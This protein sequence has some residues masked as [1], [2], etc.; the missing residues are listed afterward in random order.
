MSDQRE[1]LLERV[2]RTISTMQAI[3]ADSR[4]PLQSALDIVEPLRQL[5]DYRRALRAK[6]F[7][8]AAN[9]PGYAQAIARLKQVADTLATDLVTFQR[10]A[11]FVAQAAQAADAVLKVAIAVGA[12]AG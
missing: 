8:V 11:E 2:T 1:E 12:L 5:T 10:H 4:T 6:A 9:D 7:A 3:Q